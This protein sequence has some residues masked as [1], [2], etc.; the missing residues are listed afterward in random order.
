MFLSSRLTTQ[1]GVLALRTPLGKRVFM[2]ALGIG[3]SLRVL[4]FSEQARQSSWRFGAGQDWFG[5][6]WDRSRLRSGRFQIHSTERWM[7]HNHPESI[8]IDIVISRKRGSQQRIDFF[9]NFCQFTIALVNFRFHRLKMCLLGFLLETLSF[10]L[11]CL[12]YLRLQPH[13]GFAGLFGTT[14]ISSLI[15]HGLSLPMLTFSFFDTSLPL[16]FREESSA[17]HTLICCWT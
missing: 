7:C 12:G 4:P 8:Q 6:V 9:V 15:S 3:D 5:G 13:R 10:G 1:L 2:R 14:D 16:D 11:G 17:C